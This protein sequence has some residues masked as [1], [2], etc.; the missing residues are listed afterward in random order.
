MES[1]Q[2]SGPPSREIRLKDASVSEA[3]TPS[4]FAAPD[5]VRLNRMSKGPDGQ[6]ALGSLANAAAGDVVLDEAM[7]IL[8][9]Y[10]RLIGAKA[11][12]KPTPA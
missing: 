8:T 6:P 4:P 12:A 11:G 7:K 5:T 9:D 1:A 3:E 10:V 2:K